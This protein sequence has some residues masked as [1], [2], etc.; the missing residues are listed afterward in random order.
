MCFDHASHVRYDITQ[1][2][3]ATNNWN[4]GI[5]SKQPKFYKSL[6]GEAEDKEN[7]QAKPYVSA[8]HKAT[9]AKNIQLKQP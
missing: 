7:S 3:N 4:G 1:F 8:S 6:A 2:G 5:D 9:L